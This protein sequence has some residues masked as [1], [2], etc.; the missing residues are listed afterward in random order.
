MTDLYISWDFFDMKS[1]SNKKGNMLIHLDKFSPCS[2]E[3]FKRVLKVVEMDSRDKE[4]KEELKVYFQD[5]IFALKAS[6][7]DSEKA[8][9]AL[10]KKVETGKYQNGVMIPKYKMKEYSRQ[11]QEIFSD[12]KK[13]TRQLKQ[14]ERYLQFV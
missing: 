3:N 7:A 9:A 11:Y 2:L 6:I 1:F 4:L 10:A 13:N 14:F 8:A 5:R 12:I